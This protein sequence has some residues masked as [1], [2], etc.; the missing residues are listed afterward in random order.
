MAIFAEDGT[1]PPPPGLLPGEKPLVLATRDESKFSANDGKRQ[2]W[3]NK[4][5]Q[6]LCQKT[7]ERGIMVSGFLTLSG[8]LEVSKSICDAEL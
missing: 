7:E 3:V 8:K 1:W 6:P 2:G 5:Q 4:G